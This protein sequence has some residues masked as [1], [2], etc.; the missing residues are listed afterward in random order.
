M[1]VQERCGCT[2]EVEET[3][4]LSNSQNRLIFYKLLIFTSKNI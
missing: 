4:G 2:W 3:L 1:Y